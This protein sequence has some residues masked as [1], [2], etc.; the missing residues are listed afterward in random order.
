M[1]CNDQRW[2]QVQRGLDHSGLLVDSDGQE[3][4]AFVLRRR[5]MKKHKKKKKKFQ[6]E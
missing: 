4:F 5:E 1:S 2:A 3:N 6:E